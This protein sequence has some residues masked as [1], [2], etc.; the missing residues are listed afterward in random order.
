MTT[1]T[2]IGTYLPAWGSA[3]SRRLGDDEDAV[4]IAVAAGLAA[5]GDDASIRAGVTVVILVSRDFP[6]LEGGNG[7][8]LVGGLGLAE[9][10]GVRETIGG[11][12]AMLDAILTAA[13]GTLVVGADTG[14]RDES[15]AGSSAVLCGTGGVSLVQSG[16]V[17]RSMP[18]S[19]RDGDGHRTDYADPRLLRERGLVESMSR[20]GNPKPVAAAGLGAR[21]AASWCVGTPPALLTLGAS[22]TG[23]A[24][25]ALVEQGATGPLLA[26]EQATLTLAELGAGTAIVTRDELAPK[27]R[28]DGKLAPG[29]SV[30]ISLSAYDRAFDAKL[31]LEA[32][33]CTTCGT[34]SYPPR[35]RCIECGS[36]AP[37][38]LVALPRDAEIYTQATIRVPVPGLVSPYTLTLVEL[39]DTGVR[40]LV[41]LTGA[42]PGSTAI[43]DRGRMVF[44][45]VAVRQGVPDYGYAFQ[46]ATQIAQA[47]TTEEVAS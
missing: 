28:P 39:G 17:T 23:F 19:T 29:A 2:R 18:T 4:S 47:T 12:P 37:T 34:L 38:K 36:E 35:H 15:S 26:A 43:G 3:T 46:P 22:A 16:R 25:A 30:S 42:A 20:L 24:L 1:I 40:T 8:P 10:V 14:R 11:A 44:R 21:D 32:A 5:L 27:P 33:S 13:P 9:S 6:L 45:L 7:A 41:R 31:R